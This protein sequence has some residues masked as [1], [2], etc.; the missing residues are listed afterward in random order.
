MTAPIPLSDS[1]RNALQYAKNS[2]SRAHKYAAMNKPEWAKEAWGTAFF[3]VRIAKQE[4][5]NWSGWVAAMNEQR[6]A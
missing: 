5:R 2:R 1:E 3:W 6:A 4:R